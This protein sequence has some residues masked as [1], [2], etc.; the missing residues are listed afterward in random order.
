MSTINLNFI[1]TTLISG[2]DDKLRTAINKSY[3]FVESSEGSIYEYNGSDEEADSV[4]IS[5]IKSNLDLLTTETGSALITSYTFP[6][7]IFGNND[8]LDSHENWKAFVYGDSYGTSTYPGVYA[9]EVFSDNYIE[10][11]T[12]YPNIDKRIFNSIDST[13][14]DSIIIQPTYNYYSSIYEAET[15]IL[16]SRLIPN[17][18]D[19]STIAI[20][21]DEDRLE[22]INTDV[23]NYITKEGVFGTF[24]G[25][26]DEATVS[27]LLTPT[28]MS[29][30][31]E[32]PPQESLYYGVDID[33]D[34]TSDT[35]YDKNKNLRSYLSGAFVSLNSSGST[36]SAVTGRCSNFIFDSV[37]VDTFLKTTSDTTTTRDLFP[38][39]VSI[40]I[41]TTYNVSEAS[42]SDSTIFRQLIQEVNAEQIFMAQLAVDFHSDSDT[43]TSLNFFSNKSYNSGSLDSNTI[44]KII[45]TNVE[46]FKTTSLLKTI[47]RAMASTTILDDKK[48]SYHFVG[49]EDT[50][51][52][53]ALNNLP[54]YFFVNSLKSM[55]LLDTMVNYINTTAPF[56]ISEGSGGEDGALQNIYDF[57]NETKYYETIAFRV[58]KLNV[59]GEV[60]SNYWIY[61]MVD[62][63]EID[64]TDTQVKYNYDYTYNIYAYIIVHGIN[65]TYSNIA[66]SEP[67][68][69]DD[70]TGII[71]VQFNDQQGNSTSQLYVDADDNE[72]LDENEFATNSQATVDETV[73]GNTR[74]MADF[75]V[76]YEPS[77]KIIEIPLT[78]KSIRVL[79]H[80]SSTVDVIPYYVKNDSN[81][82]GF[83]LIKEAFAERDMPEPFDGV[84]LAY[85][86]NY[87]NS[88][89]LLPS[90]KISKNAKAPVTYLEAYRLIEKPLSYDSFSQNLLK[91]YSLSMLNEYGTLAH[92]NCE[93]QILTNQKYYFTFRS[94]TNHQHA[95]QFSEI[96]ECELINDG[97]YKYANF[98]TL[99]RSDLTPSE[100]TTTNK[101]FKKLIQ[102]IPNSS[103]MQ[104][105]T[106][107]V[108][109]SEPASSQLENLHIGDPNL[110]DP[111]WGKTFKIRLTSKKTGK[112]IDLNITYN[113][114][115]A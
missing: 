14:C 89:D 60:I 11:E 75:N 73:E 19:F 30:S 97:G 32:L 81:T 102:L 3:E 29:P 115:D 31:G 107:D 37:G 18:Y 45:S 93:N 8:E 54:A 41:P 101:S 53:G 47:S 58:E 106:D 25:I 6:V 92:T 16:D 76:T 50:L 68:S 20:A 21:E 48:Q 95:G 10:L 100:I 23:Y 84:D 112:K 24:M 98:K 83:K 70:D 26:G 34:G 69:I 63:T 114:D 61:N 71:T 72:F 87:R 49:Y 62:L 80:P 38:S 7:R 77:V 74:H 46:N 35:F 42:F 33:S 22:Q 39:Y 4:F 99:F 36:L 5:S 64:L 88:Y 13:D 51:R 110:V 86:N 28:E 17:I 91:K 85:I 109:F 111:I 94:L 27:D 82:I 59:S 52:K 96:Y 2:S 78:T 104:L 108:D 90:E 66:V 105:I 103:H 9:T 55:E 79:D 113:L 12:P 56:N 65:Y 44:S 57:A 67:I 40:Q 43:P 15:N 1:D